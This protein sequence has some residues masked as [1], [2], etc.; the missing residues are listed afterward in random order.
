MKTF[1]SLFIENS[2][3]DKHLQALS[4]LS[5]DFSEVEISSGERGK[6]HSIKL[7]ELISRDNVPFP[8]ETGYF[9]HAKN[10]IYNIT[11]NDFTKMFIE[12]RGDEDA[13]RLI[14]NFSKHKILYSYAGA[15]EE[16][17]HQNRVSVQKPHGIH[18]TWVG[19]D[20][21][22][23]LPGIYWLNLVPTSLLNKHKICISEL[24]KISFKIIELDNNQLFIQL[25]ENSRDWLKH[26]SNLDDFRKKTKSIFFKDQALEELKSASTFL[27]SISIAD[28]WK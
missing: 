19:R 3:I 24:E 14:Q 11:R 28:K 17:E 25:Y 22:K 21:E 5:E 16:F 6:K 2:E 18:E 13:I 10:A 26:T 15:F 27:E 12:C 9:L 8:I 20:F 4:E 7:C 23:Y 1:I